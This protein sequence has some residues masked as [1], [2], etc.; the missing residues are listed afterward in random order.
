MGKIKYLREIEEFISK[1]KVFTVK[2]IKRLILLKKANPD[3]A[4]LMLHNMAKRGNINRVINGYYSKYDDPMLITYCIKPSY[5]GLE[6]ALSIHG[7]WEQ[8]TNAVLLTPLRVRSGIRQVLGANIV[9][10]S[11]NKKYFFGFDYV[12]YYEFK[13]PLSDI[14]KTFIDMIFYGHYMGDDLLKV[15]KKKLDRNK[16]EG[17]LKHYGNRFVNKVK[18]FF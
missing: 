10:H 17:Y 8:E 9:V 11:L 1:S 18:S 7:L 4:Y 3:Y 2:D 16:L 12:D 15:F 6:S 5:I 13:I 14:E